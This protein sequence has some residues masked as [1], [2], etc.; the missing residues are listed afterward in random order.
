MKCLLI[1]AQGK[2]RLKQ[3]Q[4]RRV[5]HVTNP[6]RNMRVGKQLKLDAGF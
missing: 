3:F 2:K 1:L 5:F 6:Y 4:N